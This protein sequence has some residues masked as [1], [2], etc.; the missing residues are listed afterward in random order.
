MLSMI[1]RNQK[2][3]YQCNRS[4]CRNADRPSI[5]TNIA[6]VNS[7]HTPNIMYSLI[8]PQY[9]SLVKPIRKTMFHN[10]S[11]S[12]VNKNCNLNVIPLLW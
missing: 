9:E 8:A 3:I 6:S 11:E 1:Q 4:V 7:D 10:T 12:S 2:K 5:I